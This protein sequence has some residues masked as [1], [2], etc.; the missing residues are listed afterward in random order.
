MNNVTAATLAPGK[1]EI[2]KF[3]H[4]EV[5]PGDVLI[6]IQSV[7]ICGSDKHMFLG[8]ASLQ[9][10]V[11]PGHEL[12][13]NVVALGDDA[14]AQSNII[15]GPLAPGD[16]VTVTPSR[17]SCGRCW[18][19]R[20]VPHKP[21]LC[22]NRKVYGFM[23]ANHPPGLHG[24]L[25]EFMLAGPGSNIFR[26]PDEV[27]T[28]RAVMTEPAAVATRAVERAMG[29]GVPHIGEGLGIGK[30][31]AVLGCGPIGLLA[32][33][34][35]RHIG[36]DTIIATDASSKRL[37]IAQAMGADVTINLT[38][39]DAEQRLEAVQTVTNGVGPDVAIE[40]AGTPAAFAEG[41][42]MIRRGG[43]LVEVG[44]YFENGTTPLSPHTICHKDVDILGVWAYPPIQ[45]ETALSFL[46]R[47]SAPLEKLLSESIPLAKLEHG[48]EMTGREDVLKVVVEPCRTT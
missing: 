22:P 9:F 27:S 33:A 34:A 25:A 10:P 2:R 5:G 21:A 4:P 38:E 3:P 37:K 36:A 29:T 48:L 40:S 23:P 44:H 15:S 11:V 26:I 32:I 6:Q 19:C 1:V 7:G 18:Y 41:L 12:V 35:L 43:R 17:G 8:H 39:V 30:R 45:F 31:V 42:A 13:G 28:A 16:R 14:Q 20:H 46:H 47:S 24:G